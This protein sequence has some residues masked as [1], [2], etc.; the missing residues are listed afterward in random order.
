MT[1]KEAIKSWLLTIVFSYIVICFVDLLFRHRPDKVFIIVW[2]VSYTFFYFIR[3][4]KIIFKK[5][6]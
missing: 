3:N 2:S 6:K 1:K 5:G 4:R